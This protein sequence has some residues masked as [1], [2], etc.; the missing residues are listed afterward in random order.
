MK[1]PDVRP[2]LA[3]RG[4]STLKKIIKTEDGGETVEEHDGSPGTIRT[5]GHQMTQDTTLARVTE[6]VTKTMDDYTLQLM[7]HAFALMNKGFSPA[8]AM[9]ACNTVFIGISESVQ[10][11]LKAAWGNIANLSKEQH[12]LYLSQDKEFPLANHV[13][14]MAVMEAERKIAEVTDGMAKLEVSPSELKADDT[15]SSLEADVLEPAPTPKKPSESKADD[16]ESSLKAD[17]AEPAS[18]RTKQDPRVYALRKTFKSGLEFP[19]NEE[20]T[21]WFK[22]CSLGGVLERKK[23]SPVKDMHMARVYACSKC[24]PNCSTRVA[25]SKQAKKVGDDNGPDAEGN[26]TYKWEIQVR[27]SVKLST[28]KDGKAL[29]L[30]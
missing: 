21:E 29:L 10:K 24:G 7:E 23:T 1:T 8:E 2:R 9:E 5:M 11:Q 16:T 27:P 18:T 12:A 14:T 19:S 26:S 22:P 4:N 6:S 30:V 15:E 25:L 20:V 28:H 13:S 17:V 3:S